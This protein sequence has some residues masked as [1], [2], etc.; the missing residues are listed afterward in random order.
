MVSIV[1]VFFTDGGTLLCDECVMVLIV[2]VFLPMVVHCCVN[3]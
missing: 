3:V 2:A 1:A